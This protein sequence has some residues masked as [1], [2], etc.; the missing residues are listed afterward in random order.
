M[1]QHRLSIFSESFNYLKLCLKI[2]DILSY[3][4]NADVYFI[5]EEQKTCFNGKFEDE[6]LDAYYEEFEEAI[7]VCK[8]TSRCKG[9]FDKG[10]DNEGLYHLCPK[11]SIRTTV[12]T[13]CVYSK[14]G[15]QFS[16][17]SINK[18]YHSF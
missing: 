2:I 8:N 9:V 3:A 15:K 14:Y 13:S 12:Q 17:H 6:T 18:N 5:K 11:E 4:L 10:C 16:F 1:Y 7:D